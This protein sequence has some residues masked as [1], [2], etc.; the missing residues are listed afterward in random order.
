MSLAEKLDS[1]RAQ[2]LFGYV[3]ATGTPEEV[4]EKDTA[5]GFY[6]SKVF[7]K[8]PVLTAK[9]GKPTRKKKR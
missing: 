7:S 1:G 5:T 3:V 8:E 9:N 2:Q 4:A 6:L